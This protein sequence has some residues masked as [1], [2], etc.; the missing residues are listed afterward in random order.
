MVGRVISVPLG[1]AHCPRV[2]GFDSRVVDND[3]SPVV[4]FLDISLKGPFHGNTFH[5]DYWIGTR[6]NAALKGER[7]RSNRLDTAHVILKCRCRDFS[8]F[9]PICLYFSCKYCVAFSG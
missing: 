7:E 1:N 6:S 8:V 4:R 9:G 3:S 5:R 2:F